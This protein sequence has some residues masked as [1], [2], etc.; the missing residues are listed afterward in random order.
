MAKKAAGKNPLT[1]NP[2][3]ILDTS[4]TI[5]TVIMKDIRPKV[6]KLIGKVSTLK[7]NPMVAFARAISTAA[8]SAVPKP[9]LMCTPG[10][11]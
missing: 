5:N 3:T 1:W 2:L 11:R 6:K 4:K 9:P 10:T 7:I 8:T